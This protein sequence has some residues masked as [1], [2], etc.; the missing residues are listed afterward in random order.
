MAVLGASSGWHPAPDA[1]GGR[2]KGVEDL[3]DA[4]EQNIE[5]APATPWSGPSDHTG[6]DD[7]RAIAGSNGADTA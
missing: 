2:R 4:V 7:A 1:R 3:E 5:R 6:L